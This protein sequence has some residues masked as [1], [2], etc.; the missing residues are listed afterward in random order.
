M[1]VAAAS[2]IMVP[3]L[4]PHLGVASCNVEELCGSLFLGVVDGTVAATAL[5]TFVLS[6]LPRLDS[7][8]SIA[9]EEL[10]RLVYRSLRWWFVVLVQVLGLLAGRIGPL[11]GG[12][13]G[14]DLQGVDLGF[15]SCCRGRANSGGLDAGADVSIPLAGRGGEGGDGDGVADVGLF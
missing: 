15:G 3:E 6:L 14:G 13:S 5:G 1:V 10:W 8:C 12:R 2:P 7:V 4:Q 9:A 11:H